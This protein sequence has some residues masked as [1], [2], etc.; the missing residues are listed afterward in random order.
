M[1]LWSCFR[2]KCL[3][4][5]GCIIYPTTLILRHRSGCLRK[6]RLHGPC[7]DRP[8]LRCK[9]WL[10][11]QYRD[12]ASLCCIDGQAFRAQGLQPI[13]PN[14]LQQLYLVN[15]QQMAQQ[16]GSPM[17][18]P[19]SMGLQQPSGEQYLLP[20]FDNHRGR[21]PGHFG[22]HEGSRGRHGSRGRFQASDALK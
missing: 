7:R 18:P 21:G 1:P 20:G 17:L 19:G 5:P 3:Q 9:S 14:V 15:Q 2:Q 10:C 22:G 6:C 8:T 4:L 13:P 16:G 11:L 12:S